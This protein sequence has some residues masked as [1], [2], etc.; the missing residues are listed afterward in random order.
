MGYL[1]AVVLFVVLLIASSAMSREPIIRLGLNGDDYA[2]VRVGLKDFN[3]LS[4]DYKLFAYPLY[5][6]A[7]DG[8][9]ILYL[10]NHPM[11]LMLRRL[12]QTLIYYGKDLPDNTLKALV[13]YLAYIVINHGNYDY[14]TGRKILPN[15]LTYQM[16]FYAMQ[17]AFDVGVDL[18]FIKGNNA[19]EKAKTIYPYIFDPFFQSR[20]TQTQGD[21]VANS[22]LG[23]YAN[24]LTQKDIDSLSP[25]DRGCGICTYAK[26]DGHVV[27]KRIGVN[28]AYSSYVKK[29]VSDLEQAFLYCPD[30]KQKEVIK[31][32]IEFY[33]TGN[34]DT[35]K[36]MWG[37]WVQTDPVVDFIVGPVE[38][39][40]DPRGIV[41]FFE[42]AAW[43]KRDSDKIKFLRDSAGYFE[44]RMPWEE[45]F[46][47]ENPK[48][49]P[50]TTGDCLFGTGEMGAIPWAGFNLPNYADVRRKVGS[51]NVMFLNIMMSANTKARDRAI[52]AF[53]LPKYRRA[54]RRYGKKAWEMIVYLHEVIGH[55]S[56]KVAPDFKGDPRKVLGSYYPPL[57]ECRADLAALYHISDPLI[58]R[59]AGIHPAEVQPLWKTALV[60]Y[61]TST[62]IM[63]R[64]F[65]GG[66]VTEPHYRGRLLVLNYLLKSPDSGVV[67]EQTPDYYIKVVDF[68][69]ARKVVGRLL[70]LIQKIKGTG[71]VAAAKKLFDTY[72]TFYDKDI[73]ANVTKRANRIQLPK[74]HAFIYPDLTPVIKKGEIVDIKAKYPDFLDY[75]FRGFK[76]SK[77][78]TWLKRRFGPNGEKV[79]IVE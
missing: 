1:R 56:G 23:I 70:A 49:P 13:D 24:G 55:G 61:L 3:Q 17:N 41:G 77:A 7:W 27:V 64:K 75:L 37:L 65:V 5:R 52:D 30:A 15:Y 22:H 9:P 69:Q 33:N 66:R 79:F 76:K 40:K 63:H 47:A 21:V 78:P 32:L 50:A 11:S 45:R 4:K 34:E 48:S 46:K 71:D 73:K 18:D 36:K 39:I 28:G 53:Y 67:L 26:Q 20:I 74:Q 68:S 10:Q 54:V 58:A 12:F 16:F 8:D 43:V 14:R 25:E 29:I 44:S 72:G 62:L 57:E 6:A 38:Q 59:V 60:Q 35:Y 42:A 2:I 51:K 19:V 31:A